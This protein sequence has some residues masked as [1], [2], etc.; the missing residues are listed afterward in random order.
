MTMHAPHASASARPADDGNQAVLIA[1]APLRISLA[2]GGTDLPAYY[3]RFGGMV[4]STTINR[5]VYVIA[6]SL[7]PDQVS[8]VTSADYQ[9]FYRYHSAGP[10][11]W[12]GDLAL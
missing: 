11:T 9:T 3:E 8:Q 4:V 7:P 10:V 1:R 6:A 2:G 12:D 5:H